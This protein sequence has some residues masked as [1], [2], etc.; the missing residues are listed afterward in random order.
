MS[1]E[2]RN[3]CVSKGRNGQC[4]PAYSRGLHLLDVY[5]DDLSVMLEF[6]LTIINLSSEEK[7]QVI[8]RHT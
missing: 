4:N 3:E 8:L 2:E 7:V 6:P 5:P 1:A